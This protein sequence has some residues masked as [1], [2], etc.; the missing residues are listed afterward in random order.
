[1]RLMNLRN[2]RAR[3]VLSG[4]LAAALLVAG[5]A[6]LAQEDEAE[7]LSAGMFAGLKLRGIGPALMSGRIADIDLHPNDPNTWYI[8][9]GSG[10]VWK[11]VNSGT[12][13][14]PVFDKQSVYSI[15]ALTIDPSNPSRIWVGTGEDVGGRHVSF[16]DGVYLSE[17]GGANWRNV[18]LPDSE[19]I[20]QI[21]VHP[22][23]P[24]VVLV[25]A[26]GP[27]WSS[28]G[29]RGVYRTEDG[30]E[31]WTQTLGDDEWTG[32]A[33]LIA[34]PRNPDVLYAATWQ[35]HR[36]VAAYMGGGPK[37]GIHKSTD[38]GRTWKELTQGLPKGNKG[39]I[40]LAISP[41]NPDTIYAAVELDLREGGVFRSTDRGAT[42][43]KRSDTVSGGTGP[44]YYQE[45]Y[46][47]PH[48]EGRLYLMNNT[49]QISYDAGKTFVPMSN[50][51]KHG[52]DHAVAFRPDNPEYLLFGSDGGLYESFDHTATWRF[53]ANLPI[54][55]FY[56]LALDDAEPYY[57]VYGGT[58]DNNTQ[59]GPARTDNVNGIRNSDWEVVLFGDG[60]QP[61]TE[62]GNPDIVYA[63]W[64]QG[65]LVRVDRSSGELVY[66]KPQA[67]PGDAPERL[68][69]DAPI[70][71]SPHSPTRIYHASQRVWRSDNRGDS[72]TP[73]SGDLTRDQQRETLPIMGRQQSF[74]APWDMYAMSQYNTITSL[75]E[76]PLE[77]GL[78]YAG[79]DD[80]LIQ[81]SENGGESWREIEVG[82]LPGVP[83]TA[84][85]N[86][87]KADLF[88]ADT[89]YVALDNHKYGDYQ[90]YLLK[91]TDR[92]RRWQSI[93]GNL[94]E[95]HLVWR[96]VQDHVEPNLLF[97]GTEFGVFFSLGGGDEW[98][99]LTGGVPTI[100]F[101]DLAIQR[102]EN[103]L[104][105]AS[106]G[107]GF[108]V[109]DDYTPLRGLTE[110]QLES[111][112]LL[113]TPR[114][115]DWYMQG[116]PL[117]GGGNSS[118]GHAHYHAPN[119]PYGAVLTYYLP[120]DLKTAKATRREREKAL[121]SDE[122]VP[123]PGWDAIE[124]ERR[125]REPEMIL[126]VRDA[127]GNVVRRLTGPAK[128]GFHRIAWDLR[129]PAPHAIGTGGD[130]FSNV[131]GPM[132]APGTYSVDLSQTL[133][134]ETQKVADAVSFE[135]VS[136]NRGAL[137]GAEPT[138]VAAFWQELGSVQ[139]GATA[140][141]QA[142]GQTRQ[143]VKTLRLALERSTAAPAALDGELHGIEQSL[144]DLA[145]ALGGSLQREYL[146]SLTEPTVS[147]RLFHAMLGTGR[148][149]YGP[150]PSHQRSLEL[151]R[152]QFAAIRDQMNQLTEQRIPA[153]EASLREAGA[154]WTP[155]QPLP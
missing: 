2:P 117:G 45:L 152:N 145:L 106:F 58:Q 136:L 56:K 111:G 113:F 90:P 86:D 71:V 118:Q 60:H 66:I 129:F 48:H 75:A 55:Q 61:A 142:L 12:T 154:P 59:G 108:F 1:M 14:Q 52:D 102:R 62:P 5:P 100:S 83:D 155:G 20:T 13:W 93:A 92:G 32:V 149:T 126:T 4:L 144:E 50:E 95:K 65:N 54:T 151:A 35:H 26:Q 110:A 81:V 119:P 147:D 25:A 29:E 120:E 146:G 33:S 94:P 31:N 15:G 134:G 78:L 24:D 85:V 43:E 122:D 127:D 148:S 132:A 153:F 27:L 67:E 36:T 22:D 79:T 141:G 87:I 98:V 9:V 68:N 89:V 37:S 82:S 91:S 73:I 116:S 80:G 40:G 41:L 125:E 18:G 10:G 72:W 42:W 8:S 103:D 138:E 23:N 11:T 101:R 139:R 96:V 53:V 150:T 64:Q 109:F 70:L 19:H 104:V 115:A 77:A 16:G 7:T 128:K 49:T 135:V 105:G 47:S 51:N 30:G 39:K 112:P 76:S 121:D 69:W 99:E 124:A 131:S 84:F 107:R 3:N 123:F 28:G 143:R 34:D 6:A 114:D 130:Y 88:D 133:N 21:I 17:D 57:N 97:L 137:D 140:A 38:G 44:H 46:A 74:D 63:Q